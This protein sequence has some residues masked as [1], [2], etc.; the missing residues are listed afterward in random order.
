MST[1]FS[2]LLLCCTL[3][4]GTALA[5][6]MIEAL[7]LISRGPRRVIFVLTEG[8][9]NDNYVFAQRLPEV[10]GFINIES[11]TDKEFFNKVSITWNGLVCANNPVS[12]ESNNSEDFEFD[13]S[14]Q[15]DKPWNLLFNTREEA[16]CS[17][18]DIVQ[19]VV[20][21]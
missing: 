21:R 9:G 11:M 8:E 20:Y 3:I 7:N 14:R 12:V 15:I 16:G 4:C 18:G 17:E 6:Y 13:V 2:L 5:V 10:G 1:W 19:V